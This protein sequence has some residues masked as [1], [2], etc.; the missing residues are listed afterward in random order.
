MVCVAR[1]RHPERTSPCCGSSGARY[2]PVQ[3]EQVLRLS[4]FRAGRGFSRGNAT[5]LDGLKVVGYGRTE[6]GDLGTRMKTSV[7]IVTPDCLGLPVPSVLCAVPGD[8]HG[9]PR[10]PARVPRD[11]CGGDSGGP[12]FVRAKVTLP[13][14]SGDTRSRHDLAPARRQLSATQDVLVAITSRA[15]PFTQPLLGGHCGGGGTYT[16]DRK[17]AGA[18]VAGCERR[19]TATMCRSIGLSRRPSRRPVTQTNWKVHAQGSPRALDRRDRELARPTRRRGCPRSR[20]SSRKSVSRSC[21]PSDTPSR[22]RT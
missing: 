3:T 19:E 15:A 10:R 6:S 8:G 16:L 11:T 4:G 22:Q 9:R 13:E 12:V 7:P 5:G 14:C 18:C 2:R 20:R 17:T 21:H 1:N